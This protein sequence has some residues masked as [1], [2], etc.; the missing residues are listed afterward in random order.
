[1]KLFSLAFAL[2]IS[3]LATGCTTTVSYSGIS[4]KAS[5]QQPADGTQKLCT[6]PEVGGSSRSGGSRSTSV[7]TSVQTCTWKNAYGQQCEST[8]IRRNRAEFN[9][10]QGR[11]DDKRNDNRNRRP[12]NDSNYSWICR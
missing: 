1:M 7:S 9:Y 10:N 12:N 2:I 11:N 3:V 8:E 4:V 5:P 6:V